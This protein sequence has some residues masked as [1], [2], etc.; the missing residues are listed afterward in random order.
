VRQL[1]HRRPDLQLDPTLGLRELLPDAVVLDLRLRERRP[2]RPLPIGT[3]K[4]SPVVQ[5]SPWK[6]SALPSVVPV[7]ALPYAATRFSCG[8]IVFS[9]TAYVEGALLERFLGRHDLR[10]TLDR[11]GEPAVEIEEHR[12]EVDP[13]R[14]AARRVSDAD[15]EAVGQCVSP[16][17]RGRPW[18]SPASPRR[19]PG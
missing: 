1:D 3:E 14:H 7:L 9:A 5:T 17:A 11:R 19:P 6:L 2:C 4:T 18:P 12:L 10:S 13:N 16:P 8:R 15:A